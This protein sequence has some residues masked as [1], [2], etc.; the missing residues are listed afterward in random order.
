ME[1]TKIIQQKFNK[2]STKIQQ[3]F[4]KIQQNS[5]NSTKFN[6]IIQRWLSLEFGFESSKLARKPR[7]TQAMKKKRLDFAKK[8]AS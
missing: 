7:L 8:H 5:T 2:N 3:K 1:S 6:K 4:N